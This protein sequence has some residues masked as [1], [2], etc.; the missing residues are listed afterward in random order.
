MKN[1]IPFQLI[2]LVLL[3]I[4]QIAFAIELP[5][6]YP[7]KM[8]FWVD[9]SKTATIN[10]ILTKPFNDINSN[11]FSGGYTRNVHWF[12][13]K[14]TPFEDSNTLILSYYMQGLDNVQLYLP[15]V[16][17]GFSEQHSGDLLAFHKREVAHRDLN[18]LVATPNPEPII[19]Y[20]RL[21]TTSS[22]V[23]AITAWEPQA[24]EQKNHIEYLIIGIVF[25]ILFIML[26]INIGLWHWFYDLTFRYYFYYLV[27]SIIY[28][29]TMN[30]LIAEFIIQDNGLLNHYIF[31]LSAVIT[32]FFATLFYKYKLNI[33]FTETPI[34]YWIVNAYQLLLIACIFAVFLDYFTEVMAWVNRFMLLLSLLIFVRAFRVWRQNKVSGLIIVALLFSILAVFASALTLLG[35]IKTQ[36]IFIYAPQFGIIATML[37]L[38]ILLIQLV[39][40]LQ[41]DQKIAELRADE[42]EKNNQL[43]EKFIAMLTHELKTPLSVIRLAITKQI[44]Q[45]S[46]RLKDHAILAINDIAMIIDRCSNSEKITAGKIN[47]KKVP[48]FLITLVRQIIIEQDKKEQVVLTTTEDIPAITTDPDYLRVIISNLLDNAI[49]YSDKNTHIF[50]SIEVIDNGIHLSIK[51]MP[52]ESGLPD[53]SQVFEKYYRS[54][55]AH[56]QIGAGLGLYIVKELAIQLGMKIY[57]FTTDKLVVFELDIPIERK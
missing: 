29:A 50:I 21:Q 6:S 43:Q 44:T 48:I 25:G 33:T 22:S 14:L 52:N 39:Q 8:A 16:D 57:Y 37:T 11:A 40:Q 56:H 18:F 30:G 38:Q 27:S 4:H 15:K 10:D 1:I 47:I 9:E 19:A 53:A 23:I 28:L 7:V 24:F 51:N 34:L 42:A 49:K 17:G 32:L 26:S 55:G 46:P 13:I 45:P 31:S 5:I 54:T 12:K 2:A 35:I 3:L 20:I 36:V 41:Y